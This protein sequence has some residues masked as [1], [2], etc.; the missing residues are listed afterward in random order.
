MNPFEIEMAFE[1]NDPQK[2]LVFFET[3]QIAILD[4][5]NSEQWKY[6]QIRAAYCAAMSGMAKRLDELEKSNAD[7]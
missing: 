4:T 6:S 1:Y 3:V 2:Y 5:N 7:D